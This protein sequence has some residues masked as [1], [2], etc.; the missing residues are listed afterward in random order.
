LQREEKF[1]KKGEKVHALGNPVWAA[2]ADFSLALYC[3]LEQC[4]SLA[5][6]YDFVVTVVMWEAGLAFRAEKLST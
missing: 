2:A 3:T 1:C 6:F 4:S 5:E